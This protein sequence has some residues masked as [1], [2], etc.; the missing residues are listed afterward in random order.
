MNALEQT[1]AALG[2]VLNED[3]LAQAI[4][5]S[6]NGVKELREENARVTEIASVHEKRAGLLEAELAMI[7]QAL[8]ESV[9]E[10]KRIDRFNVELVTQLN[11]VKGLIG[12]CFTRAEHAQY[13]PNVVPT[14]RIPP[15]DEQEIP[16]FLQNGPAIKS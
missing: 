8:A 7:R 15:Q 16:K 4:K 1:K 13:L 2:P 5:L 3:P 14:E 6:F 12:E 10:C 11:N 9:R